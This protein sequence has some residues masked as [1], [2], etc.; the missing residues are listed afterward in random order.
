MRE[1]GPSHM[2]KGS[3]LIQI[4]RREL[5]YLQENVDLDDHP[6]KDDLNYPLDKE[7]LNDLKEKK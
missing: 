6:E 4:K 5:N 1:G 3:M 2:E 7:E